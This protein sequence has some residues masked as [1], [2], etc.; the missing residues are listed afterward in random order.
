MDK[1]SDNE[2]ARLVNIAVDSGYFDHAHMNRMYKKLVHC[3]SG[4]YKN[5]RFKNLDYNRID[6]YIPDI[7]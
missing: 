2:D 5:N 4:E 6:S 1:I 7:K 3:S